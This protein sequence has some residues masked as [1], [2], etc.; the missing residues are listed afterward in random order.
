MSK[1]Y[2]LALTQAYRVEQHPHRP[3]QNYLFKNVNLTAKAKQQNK[4]T[5][6]ILYSSGKYLI[7]LFIIIVI[8]KMML[9]QYPL[10]TVTTAY[11]ST[12]ILLIAVCLV[13]QFE[14]NEFFVAMQRCLMSL[15]ILN[16]RNFFQVN[17]SECYRVL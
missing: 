7:Y 12:Y 9:A 1:N 17:T 16:E 3:D 15:R 4:R 10:P 8:N 14:K 6:K 5:K 11:L 13:P 2:W